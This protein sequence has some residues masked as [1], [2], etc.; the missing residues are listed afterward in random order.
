MKNENETFEVNGVKISLTLARVLSLTVAGLTRKQRAAALGISVSTVN[1][2]MDTLTDRFNIR[3]CAKLAV[4]AAHHG[5]DMQGN[6]QGH[7]LFH[8][9]PNGRDDKLGKLPW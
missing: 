8:K 2:Y 7:Y 1:T 5:F 6:F 9:R 3:P 4:Y